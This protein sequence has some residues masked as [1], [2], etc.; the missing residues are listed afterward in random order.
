MQVHAGLQ[1]AGSLMRERQ[2]HTHA[3]GARSFITYEPRHV[4]SPLLANGSACVRRPRP[5][6]PQSALDE[7]EVRRG[8]L[9]LVSLKKKKNLFSLCGGRAL[10]RAARVMC[11][12]HVRCSAAI[13]TAAV[14][15]G[16]ARWF[17]FFFFLT[18]QTK[19]EIPVSWYEPC[20]TPASH[21]AR[22]LAP[23]PRSHGATACRIAGPFSRLRHTGRCVSGRQTHNKVL[24][25]AEALHRAHG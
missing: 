20:M 17:F 16:N 5:P 25:N 7:K 6:P 19:A 8:S 4:S 15:E 23:G 22:H 2:T 12:V 18:W 3:R 14:E 1:H 9:T 11:T 13:R 21:V 10:N 24:K